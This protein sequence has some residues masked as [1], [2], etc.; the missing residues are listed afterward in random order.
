MSKASMT[1][2]GERAF[3]LLWFGQTVSQFGSQMTM[4]AI[5]LIAALVLHAS[6]LDMGV[7]LALETAP[8]LVLA[9]PAGALIDRLDR[10]RILIAADV[11]RAAAMALLPAAAA[12]GALSMPLLYATTLMIGGLTVFFDIAYQSYLP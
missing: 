11:G 4:V 8:F 1:S 12:V 10:R 7:L 9:L 3:R 6:P 2:A 5:P